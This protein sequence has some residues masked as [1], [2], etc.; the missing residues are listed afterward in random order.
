[1]TYNGLRICDLPVQAPLAQG[2]KERL[3]LINHVSLGR[4]DSAALVG[5]QSRR[6]TTLIQNPQAPG[7]L[8][9]LGSL[10]PWTCLSIQK[11]CPSPGSTA[12]VPLR[13]VLEPEATRRTQTENLELPGRHSCLSPMSHYEETLSQKSGIGACEQMFTLS[14]Q[15]RREGKNPTVM[16][17]M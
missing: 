2:R 12:L 15:C 9:S 14:A 6:R 13:K 17:T 7:V 5:S 10:G 11:P 1:M 3:L 8:D 4:L 16:E